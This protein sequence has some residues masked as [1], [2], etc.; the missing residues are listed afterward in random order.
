MDSSGRIVVGVDGSDCAALALRWAGEE[1]RLRGAEL[2]VV[3]AWHIAGL[4]RPATAEPGV[5]PPL[6]DYERQAGEVL[7]ETVTAV[8]GADHGLTLRP[9]V[10][11]GRA[12]EGLLAAAEGADLLVVGSR[13]RGGFTGLLLGSVSAQCVQFAPC[14]VVVVRSTS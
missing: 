13:G 10:H 2:H 7:D 9:Q 4:P 3:Y 8:L 12:A 5:A 11:H 6:A 1:A 14:P